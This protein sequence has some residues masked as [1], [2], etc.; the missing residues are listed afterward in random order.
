MRKSP[1]GKRVTLKDIAKEMEISVASVSVA[2]SGKPGVTEELREK[3][4]QKAQQ[5][6]YVVD[7]TARHLVTGK[8]NRVGIFIHREEILEETDTTDTIEFRLLNY[9]IS[10]LSKNGMTSLFFVSGGAVDIDKILSYVY[11]EKMAGVLITGVRDNDDNLSKL[12][13]INE[14]PVIMFDYLLSGQVNCL[15]SDSD[16]AISMVLNFLRAYNHE[17]IAIVSGPKHTQISNQRILAVQKYIDHHKLSQ[18]IRLFPSDF[19]E[20][21][22]F[23]T[24]SSI[25]G[26]GWLPDAIFCFSDYTSLG[27]IKALH[28]NGFSVPNDISVIGFDDIY[29]A[30]IV[31]PNGLTTVKQDCSLYGKK[32]CE[33]IKEDKRGEIIKI[34]VQLAIRSTCIKRNASH[35]TLDAMH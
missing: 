17:K 9:L 32:I 28:Q 2:L 30:R 22:G 24:T 7:E 15:T 8:T 4:N 27:V 14:C 19:T 23:Q 3:I 18:N 21:S 33:M 34:P 10:E 12:N 20:K 16:Q 5:L 29:T 26:S 1:S 25:L 11:K 6:G 31:P 35:T 13:Q